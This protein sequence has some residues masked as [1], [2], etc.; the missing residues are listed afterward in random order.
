[1][2]HKPIRMRFSK[3]LPELLKGPIRARM[4]GHVEVEDS[5]RADLHRQEDIHDSERRS[6]G[7]KEVARDDRLDVVPNKRGPALIGSAARPVRLQMLTHSS[8]RNLDAELQREFIRDSSL[9][10]RRILASHLANE[11]SHVS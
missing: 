3:N 1:M 10:P 2:N 11:F 8:G 4:F 6:D 5:S 9:A 7:N